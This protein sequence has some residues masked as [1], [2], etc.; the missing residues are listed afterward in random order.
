MTQVVAIEDGRPVPGEPHAGAYIAVGSDGH[1]WG[2]G[3]TRAK[4][5]EDAEGWMGEHQD[6]SRMAVT[7]YAATTTLAAY[8]EEWGS[9]GV[10][11]TAG[12]DGVARLRGE[13]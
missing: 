7:V 13:G 2:I 12:A 4:A 3:R 5:I 10:E 9:I 6:R 1:I 11:W 8:V